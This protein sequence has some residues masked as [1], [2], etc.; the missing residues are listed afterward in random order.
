MEANCYRA[1][2]RF[3]L[4][5]DNM[6]P[7]F[8]DKVHMLHKAISRPSPSP[9]PW[10]DYSEAS[11]VSPFADKHKSSTEDESRRFAVLLHYPPRAFRRP[12]RNETRC[13]LPALPGDQE[14]TAIGD[15]TV[16]IPVD[17]DVLSVEVRKEVERVFL[18]EKGAAFQLLNLGEKMAAMRGKRHPDPAT[19]SLLVALRKV[20][21]PVFVLVDL[22][23]RGA[24]VVATV[25]F[26]S[27]F[28]QGRVFATVKAFAPLKN[29]FLVD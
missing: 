17:I 3:I 6:K 21:R 15:G 7:V 28:I 2:C 20:R 1:A 16:L 5:D 9:S 18:V 11:S 12:N 4:C 23:P 19:R 13:V 25:R 24:Q 26:G 22:D 10:P 14:P 8:G 27:L 29:G